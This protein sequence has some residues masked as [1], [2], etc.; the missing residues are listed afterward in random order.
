MSV[1]HKYPLDI[2][3]A[4]ELPL[5]VEDKIVLI[6]VQRHRI[7]L[8]ALTE[9][10]VPPSQEGRTMPHEPTRRGSRMFHVFATGENVPPGLTHVGSCMTDDGALV[11][12]VFE[13]VR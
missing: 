4:T 6:A 11:W 5:D 8:W 12:H 1:V 7:C 10:W 3:R 9:H 2:D 13:A